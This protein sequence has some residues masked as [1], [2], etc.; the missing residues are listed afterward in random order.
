M[1]TISYLLFCARIESLCNNYDAD[2]L[3]SKS[4]F[5]L[6]DLKHEILY[7][8]L[9]SITL[10]GKDEKLELVKIHLSNTTFD[11]ERKELEQAL[12]NK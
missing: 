9:G 6:L 11:K 8:D 4:L 7:E 2:L 1:F 12:K 5:S 3:I 10:K